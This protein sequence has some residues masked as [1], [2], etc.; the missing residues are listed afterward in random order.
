MKVKLT[1]VNQRKRDACSWYRMIF[2]D[3]LSSY[4]VIKEPE[5]EGKHLYVCIQKKGSHANEFYHRR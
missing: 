3:K 2:K 4:L 1:V 5:K